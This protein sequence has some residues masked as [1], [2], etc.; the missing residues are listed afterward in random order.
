MNYKKKK[1]AIIGYGIEGQDVERYLKLK[2]AI[3]TILDQK[4]GDNYLSNLDKFDLII[5][6]PGVYPYKPELKN[7]NITTPT[8]IFFEEFKGKIIGVTGT[9]G[10][11]TTSTLIYNILRSAGMSVYLGGNI[12][13]PLLELL[14]KLTSKSYVIMEISSFQLIDLPISPDIAVVLNITSDHMDW[15]KNQNEYIDA[16]KNIVR[17]QKSSDWAVLNSEYKNSKNF[18]KETK[19]NI[20]FFSKKTLDRK[21]KHQL[22]LRGEHNLENIAAAVAVSNILNINKKIILNTVR[23]FKGLEHRLEFVKFFNEVGFF[24]DSFATGPQPTIAAIKSFTENET[25]ILG[26]SDKGLDYKELGDVINKSNNIKNIILVG[27][28]AKK[29]EKYISNKKIM[30]RDLGFTKMKDIVK[31]AFKISKHGYVVIL[32]PASASFD[33]FENYKDRGNQFKE[34]VWNLS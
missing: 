27:T 22:I 1:V 14:P 21:Y 3:V 24:N 28:T 30:I 10:K 4:N 23:K 13:K 5:R 7:L 34:A 31:E 12:G 32:S 11:G 16:K 20:I 9:K 17:F 15:H 2:G 26:G 33:M 25:L 8:R 18:G 29:I 19:A 6:S